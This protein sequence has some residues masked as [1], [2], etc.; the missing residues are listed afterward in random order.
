MAKTTNGPKVDPAVIQA[1]IEQLQAQLDAAKAV[2]ASVPPKPEDYLAA[3]KDAHARG[4]AHAAVEHLI[5]LVEQLMAHLG[6]GQPEPEDDVPE[7]AA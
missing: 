7:V 4:N 2:A 5:V 1:T 3:A 6:I